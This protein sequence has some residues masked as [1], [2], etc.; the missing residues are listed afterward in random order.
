M[1]FAVA[2]GTGVWLNLGRTIAFRHHG[3]GFKHFNASWE[4]DMAVHA[5][6]AGYDTIQ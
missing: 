4:T 5:R 3:E 2:S 1:W 6:A